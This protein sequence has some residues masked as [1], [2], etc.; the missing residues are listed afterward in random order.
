MNNLK[1]DMVYITLLNCY[2]S[3]DGR[4]EHLT[5]DQVVQP[6]IGHISPYKYAWITRSHISQKVPLLIINLKSKTNRN[7]PGHNKHTI[8][9][10]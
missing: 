6:Y 7:L 4:H 1:R 8:N 9:I 10:L 2:V 3:T 5:C